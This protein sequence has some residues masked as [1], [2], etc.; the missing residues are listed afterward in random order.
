MDSDYAKA[1]KINSQ[2]LAYARTIA[3]KGAKLV[4]VADKIEQKI[5]DLGG[6]LAC[7]VTLSCD[8]IAAHYCPEEED[9]TIL[10]SQVL[11]IDIGVHVN[12]KIADAAITIDLSGKY[13]DLV[14]AAEEARDKALAMIKPGVTLSQIGSVIQSSITK[15]G[16]APIRN[17]SGHRL[18]NFELHASPSIPNVINADNTK[19]EKGWAIAIEPFSTNGAG[20]IQDSDYPTIFSLVNK[21]PVRSPI[22]RE[23]LAFIEEEYQAL[24]FAKRWLTKKFGKG[25]TALA[26]R[27]LSQAGLLEAHPPLIEKNKGIVAQ[28]EHTI[29]VDDKS[30]ITTI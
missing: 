7:P 10:D 14:K 1:G 20:I 18:E 16:F 11:K 28:A 26:L 9:T 24:P 19:L 4:D 22:A 30:E 27:E 21:K 23:V 15:Y 25:K 6:K 2:A 12:G 5:I 8:H 3:K 29:F 13:G 17:L